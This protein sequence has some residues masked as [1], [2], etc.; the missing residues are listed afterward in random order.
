MS[1]Y[2]RRLFRRHPRRSPV[3]IVDILLN[4]CYPSPFAGAGRRQ[5]ERAGGRERERKKKIKKKSGKADRYN[6][7]RFSRSF[8][9]RVVF[10]NAAPIAEEGQAWRMKRKAENYQFNWSV[11]SATE[12]SS[13]RTQIWRRRTVE[14]ETK[15]RQN[16]MKI[17]WR[18]MSLTK[19]SKC[20]HGH[21]HH[22]RTTFGGFHGSL[23]SVS[24]A[25]SIKRSQSKQFGRQ[26]DPTRACS[27]TRTRLRF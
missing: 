16:E 2:L 11:V 17:S 25:R 13:P 9:C 7:P 12:R 20:H 4:R 24:G 22:L 26:C 14:T 5:H 21:H 19:F 23:E 1:E 10:L 15:S 3:E 27:Q 6:R 18:I 8:V